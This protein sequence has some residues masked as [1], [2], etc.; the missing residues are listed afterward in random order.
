MS[1][2]IMLENVF[3]DSDKMIL[4]RAQKE[5]EITQ[6]ELAEK[7]GTTQSA[8]SGNMRRDRMSM[9]VFR[10]VLD[11]LDYEIVIVDRKTGEPKWRVELGEK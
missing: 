3:D 10:D 5:R 4:K 1:E 8:L 7:M 11:A 6:T 9:D 2:K